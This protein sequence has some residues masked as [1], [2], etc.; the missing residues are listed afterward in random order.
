MS[1]PFKHYTKIAK[2]RLRSINHANYYR[3]FHNETTDD[4][5]YKFIMKI[6]LDHK[7]I[8]RSDEVR[9]T[10]NAEGLTFK[11][12][13][14]RYLDVNGSYCMA[15][16]CVDKDVLLELSIIPYDFIADGK[17]IVGISLKAKSIRIIAIQ[18]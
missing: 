13:N 16:D 18:H 9:L 1:R 15:E 11:T 8:T 5:L 7:N 2:V 6:T 4:A 14:T 3:F 12:E 10:A 17:R